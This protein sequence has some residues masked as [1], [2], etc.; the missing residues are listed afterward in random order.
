MPVSRPARWPRERRRKNDPN[1][2]KNYDFSADTI[3]GEL[4]R[5]D[6]ENLDVRGYEKHS[7]LI[8]L[9]MDFIREIV[10]SA[11]EMSKTRY[12]SSLGGS[13][14]IA[15]HAPPGQSGSHRAGAVM[16]DA[17]VPLTFQI[18]KGDQ[19]VRTETLT[20]DIVK[21]GKLSSSH[22]RIDDEQVPRMHAV[23]EVTGPD[24][25]Y[26]NYYSS[27]GVYKPVF[28][29]CSTFRLIQT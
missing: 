10:K 3:E 25:N 29:P 7:S 27:C 2:P 9:R 8:H 16:A 26:F 18:F 6:G 14:L 19:L 1:K 22:L 4:A 12:F 21:I 23:I 13:R 20:Q 5:P 24:D 17:K 15:Q 28:F 11:E